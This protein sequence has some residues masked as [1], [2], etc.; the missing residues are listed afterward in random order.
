MTTYSMSHPSV[1][2][3]GTWLRA[4]GL[5][6]ETRLRNRIFRKTCEELE[7]L[8]DAELADI[9]ICRLNIRDIARAHARRA[10]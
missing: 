6:E 4:L 9:G 3:L 8:T 2:V 5:D 1:S 10:L 7:Q